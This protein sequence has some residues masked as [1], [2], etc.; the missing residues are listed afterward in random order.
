MLKF[1]KYFREKVWWSGVPSLFAKAMRSII[2][3]MARVEFFMIKKDV[4]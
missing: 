3:H 4:S 1:G 2:C